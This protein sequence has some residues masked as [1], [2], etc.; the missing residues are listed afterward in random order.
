MKNE[1]FNGFV[2]MRVIATLSIELYHFE[3]SFPF[4]E[5]KQIMSTAYLYVEFFFLISR[6]LITM[7][8]SKKEKSLKK[9]MI[10]RRYYFR[11][12]SF[13]KCLILIYF[14]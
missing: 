3:L 12:N 6:F 5:G 14:N 9:V 8:L 1:H 10:F 2:G 13:T 4:M 11:Q 7:E